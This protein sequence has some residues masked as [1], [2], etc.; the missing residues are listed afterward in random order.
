MSATV[1]IEIKNETNSGNRKGWTKHV[2]S[3]NSEKTNGYAFVGEF[4]NDKEYDLPV[5]AVL[6]QKNP[7]GSVKH[8]WDAGVC[9]VVEADGTLRRVHDDTYAWHKQFL[10]FRD[11][12]AKTLNGQAS[13]PANDMRDALK[14]LIEQ[15]GVEAVQATLNELMGR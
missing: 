12:V 11:L 13:T 10:S 7:E 8:G 5:G 6:V 9:L 3:V 15:Y 14:S 4:L 2:T 1:R